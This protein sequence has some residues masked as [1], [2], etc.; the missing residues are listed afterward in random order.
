MFGFC[1]LKERWWY[2]G[3]GYWISGGGEKWLDYDFIFE[4]DMVGFGD[5]WDVEFEK[6]K[7]VKKRFKVL[8]WVVGSMGLFFVGMGK[9][10][11]IRFVG[12]RLEVVFC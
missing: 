12:I 2:F 3:L 1:N 5:E 11:G 7:V 4:V 6:K 8:V 9:V 10:W